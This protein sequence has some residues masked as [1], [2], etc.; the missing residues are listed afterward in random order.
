M[1]E[2]DI[3]GK[4]LEIKVDAEELARRRQGWSPPPPRVTKGHLYVY[5]RLAQ[6]ADKGAVIKNRP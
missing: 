4:L 3:P 2:I 6:S 1:I 5:S